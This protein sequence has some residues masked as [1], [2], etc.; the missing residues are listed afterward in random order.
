[1]R[2]KFGRDPMAG[3]K[4]SDFKVYNRISHFN[5]FCPC[6]KILALYNKLANFEI[7]VVFDQMRAKVVTNRPTPNKNHNDPG[8]GYISYM[9]ST[10]TV[11]N[12]PSEC[13]Y[14]SLVSQNIRG[15]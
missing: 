14:L 4:K 6:S 11:M 10:H 2:A 9:S 13:K 1:M 7:M 5:E 12:K 8:K 15:L 3:S